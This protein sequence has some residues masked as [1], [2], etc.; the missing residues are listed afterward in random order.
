M[1][2][3]SNVSFTA[4]AF[5]I[6]LGGLKKGKKNLLKNKLQGDEY[7]PYIRMPKGNKGTVSVAMPDSKIEAFKNWLS[8]NGI[9]V[10][11]EFSG[12]NYTD[13]DYQALANL[14]S[15]EIRE[16][17][18]TDRLRWLTNHRRFIQHGKQMP[19]ARRNQNLRPN[20]VSLVA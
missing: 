18:M 1:D 10:Y 20:H 14:P 8:R 3:I 11:R 9:K 12:K 5:T 7:I 4:A 16:Q 13:K 6:P 17:R 2:K 19:R 15:Q